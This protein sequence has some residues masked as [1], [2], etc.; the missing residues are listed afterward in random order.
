MSLLEKTLSQIEPQD[1]GCRAA[2]HARLEQLTMPHWALGRLMDIAEDLAGMTRSIRPPVARKAVVVMAGDHGVAASGVSQYPQEVTVQMIHNFVNGGAG[3]NALARLVGAQVIVVDA[4]VA[5]DL[6]PLVESGK[7]IN[8]RVAPGTANIQHGPAMTREQAIRSIEVGIEVAQSLADSVDMFATGEMGIANTTPSSAIVAALTCCEVEE[9]TG[10]GTGID[11]T[12][13]QNKIAVI[14]DALR[15][16][17]PDPSDA[18]DVLAKVG[19]YEIGA[20][21]G[22]ILAS[23]AMKKP[24]VVDGF[25]TTAAA[26]I[27]Q[28]LSPASA[29]YMIAAHRSVEPGHRAAQERLGKEPLLDLS[30][31]LGEGTGAALA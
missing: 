6:T 19:G 29:Q 10:R 15:V 11:D 25:I 23:A 3:C 2:A 1:P 14:K 24:V 4:G 26:L 9:L 28:G 5:G 18:L 27:A 16:N 21:A 22:L 12:R 13:L 30:L 20:L 8:K 17:R 31:R 7:I